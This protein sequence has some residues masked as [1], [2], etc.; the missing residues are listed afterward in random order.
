M[1]KRQER[2][3]RDE[4]KE[5]DGG[6]NEKI[7]EVGER[8]RERCLYGI[9]DALAGAAKRQNTHKINHKTAQMEK[10][11]VN[12]E[13]RKRPPVFVSLARLPYSRKVIQ[14][15]THTIFS[16]AHSRIVFK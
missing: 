11:R 8:E 12:K 15:S 5:T 6:G 9:L 2:S 14:K 7:G 10:G 3:R 13:F 16:V 1:T 4:N